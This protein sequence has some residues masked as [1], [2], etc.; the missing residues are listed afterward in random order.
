MDF[1]VKNALKNMSG[2]EESLD[3]YEVGQARMVVVGA[4]VRC[5][6]RY[7]AQLLATIALFVFIGLLCYFNLFKVHDQ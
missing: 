3:N 6:P 5:V 4:G 2:E 1:L 7:Y